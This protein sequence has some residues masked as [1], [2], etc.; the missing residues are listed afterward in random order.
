MKSSS[1]RNEIG[2]YVLL[3]AI[4]HFFTSTSGLLVLVQDIR[5]LQHLR[6]ASLK[7]V[8]QLINLIASRQVD[9]IYFSD[10]NRVFSIYL[11]RIA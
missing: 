5:P 7:K 2:T 3:V 8:D 9:Q 1:S 10:F 6:T 4:D 11:K